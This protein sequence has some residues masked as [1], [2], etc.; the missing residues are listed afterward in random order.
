MKTLSCHHSEARCSARARAT[1]PVRTRPRRPRPA[2]R[3]RGTRAL[4]RA[5]GARTLLRARGA[6]GHLRA[7]ALPS[8]LALAI[9]FPET[10]AFPSRPSIAHSPGNRRCDRPASRAPASSARLDGVL[11]PHPDGPQP[12]PPTPTPPV[13]A[14]R[15]TLPP[16]AS[17]PAGSPTCREC[18]APTCAAT[19]RR[20]GRMQAGSSR[21]GSG[22]LGDPS[23]TI[24]PW[25]TRPRR[26]TNRRTDTARTAPRS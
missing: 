3:P 2:L 15:L 14:S 10:R 20:L 26:S 5:R 21:L 11:S 8:P 7:R 1:R 16:D 9:G 22:W 19:V 12:S 13:R 6:R 24:S 25:T 4:L 18:R 23:T 17:S